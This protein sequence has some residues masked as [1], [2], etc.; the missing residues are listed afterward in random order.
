MKFVQGLTLANYLDKVVQIYEQYGVK[1]FDEGNP[2]SLANRLEYFLKV[3]DAITYA[4]DKRVVHRDLKPENIMIGQFREVYVMDWGIAGIIPGKDPAQLSQSSID[5]DADILFGTTGFID[6]ASVDDPTPSPQTDIY[7]LGIILYQIVTLFKGFQG[8]THNEVISNARKGKQPAIKHRF[9]R[10]RIDPDL[11]AIIEKA[12]A[13]SRDKRYSS[14]HVLAV[15]IRRYLSNN[16]VSCRPDNLPRKA[17]RR[18]QKNL[19]LTVSLALTLILLLAGLTIHSLLK[20]NQ[21]IR[22]AKIRELALTEYQAAVASQAYGLDSHFLH[23]SHLL[24]R[25]SHK[26]NQCMKS[27]NLSNPT[28][29]E[30]IIYSSDQFDNPQL[31]PPDLIYAPAYKKKISLDYPVYK[32]APGVKLEPVKA[33]MK[34]LFNL[35]QDFLFTLLAS[36]FEFQ[37][38]AIARLKDQSINDGLPIM[39]IY[40]GFEKGYLVSFPGKGS[41]PETYDP[42]SRPWY[43]ENQEQG[44][45]QWGIPYYDINGLGI[46]LPCTYPL[47]DEK[48]NVYGVAAIDVTLDYL[49]S[50]L[51]TRQEDMKA[52]VRENTILDSKGN[53]LISSLQQ[54]MNRKKGVQDNRSLDLKPYP[55]S[56]IRDQILNRKE[57]LIFEVKGAREYIYA[58]ALIPS[59][60]WHYLEKV[61]LRNLLANY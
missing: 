51:M 19:Q 53:I 14:V 50:E 43:I 18:I 37:P 7:A 9:S 60:N 45:F 6:P 36:S 12:R 41:Y 27:W 8:N 29:Q 32:L 55:D 20:R 38:E 4:H 1:K 34:A 46:V 28:L 30:T 61:E 25:I 48:N 13:P 16:E 40:V 24:A 5:L 59:L 57:G 33:E 17:L 52:N 54:N 11:S 47:Y 58:F 44:E 21:A 22:Q 2:S 49:V 10:F 3:C 42:R 35:R 23:F 56:F 15:D 26:V 39:W 31:S